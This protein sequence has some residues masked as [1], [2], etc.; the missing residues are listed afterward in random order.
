[1]IPYFFVARMENVW[2]VFMHGNTVNILTIYIASKM[3]TFVDYETTFPTQLGLLSKHRIEQ[4]RT[5]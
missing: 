5:N 3:R 4:P 1:M 2:V